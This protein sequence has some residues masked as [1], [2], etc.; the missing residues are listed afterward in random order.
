[1][2]NSFDPKQWGLGAEA[3]KK[4]PVG[5]TSVGKSE[6]DFWRTLADDASAPVNA[7]LPT[8]PTGAES[9]QRLLPYAVSAAILLVAA[10]GAWIERS[11]PHA[12]RLADAAAEPV[13]ASSSA[14][15]APDTIERSLTLADASGLS[16]M[17]SSAGVSSDESKGAIAAATSALSGAGEIHATMVLLPQGGVT[18]LQRLQ[19]SFADGSGA[20]VDRGAD[21]AFIARKV[22]ADLTRKIRVV[23]G[24]LDSQ[25]FYTSAV[26]AGLVDS[27]IPEFINAFAYDFNL[28]SEVSPGDTFEVAYEQSVNGRGEAVGAPQLLY[29][30]LTT[31]GKSKALYRFQAQG[32]AAPAWYD[33]NGGS[34][35]R[36][37]MRTP[38]DGAR[39]TSV[40][41]MRFH[42][43]LHYTRMHEGIDF[44]APIGTPIYAAADGVVSNASPTTCAGNMIMIDHAKGLQ[45]RYFHSSHYAAGLHVGQHVVQG[46]TVGYVGVT[47]TCTTGPHLHY[48]TLVGGVHVD[49]LSIPVDDA[50]R[51]L[52]EG[53]AMQGFLK[54]RD[55]ID[56]AR[57]QQAD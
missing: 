47:G 12:A 15:R 3:P 30:S 45:T 4:A 38:I 20:V 55:R 54:E 37:M 18:H 25:S 5:P 7:P 17:L 14:P 19:A 33:G 34:I 31:P 50:A 40:Y 21:G 53:G 52:L 22:A 2:V 36:G 1:M 57:A 27:L 23:R 6:G 42:P 48:E 35:K 49:P 32:E 43:V 16:G 8:G 51:K 11:A 44:A 9:G 28:A 13:A 39:I 26:A 29:A 10:T 24:E 56:V 46:E 41:G